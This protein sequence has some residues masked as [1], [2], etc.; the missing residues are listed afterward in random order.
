MINK[1]LWLAVLLLLAL[2]GE[3]WPALDAGTPWALPDPHFTVGAVETTDAAKICSPGWA[4][5]VREQL[6]PEQWHSLKL[7]I[8]HWYGYDG[9][10]LRNYELDHLIPLEVGGSDSAANLW[11]QPWPQAHLKDRDENEMHDEICS[12]QITPEQAQEWFR[13]NG[14]AK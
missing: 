11:P 1:P 12:G 9:R 8:M 7:Q 10:P 3:R 13:H 2:A 6:T 5:H 14:W 4:R